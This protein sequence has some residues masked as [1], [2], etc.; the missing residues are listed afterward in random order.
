MRS[1][2]VAPLA[3][4]A[5]FAALSACGGQASGTTAT[6]RPRPATAAAITAAAV[7]GPRVVAAGDIAC[8]PGEAATAYG[9]LQAA[10]ARIARRRRPVAAIL[11]GDLQYDDA[12]ASEWAAFDASWGRLPF[13]LHPAPGNHEYNTPGATGYYDYFGARA[14][15]RG[16]GWYA[17]DVGRWRLYA[18][19]SNCDEVGCAAGSAQERWLRR[20]LAADPR[21]CVLAFWH[22]PRF[23][24]GLHGDSP[25][26]APIWATLQR[27]RADLV[28]QGHDHDYERFDRRSATGAVSP[29]GV[30][31]FVIGTGGK[32]SYPALRREPG[33]RRVVMGR[34]GI[35]ELVLGDEAWRWWYRTTDGQAPDTGT[36]RCR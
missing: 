13:A 34:F 20:D 19:N 9:C 14:G 31:S 28:I 5:T 7:S 22:H 15:V 17:F 2:R 29:A 10:T 33:S 3:L 12:A 30:A 6:D 21:R 4:L 23:S 16:R 24:S 1:C 25:E 35:L 32:S 8:A 27:A 11:P 18:L 26:M 36:A